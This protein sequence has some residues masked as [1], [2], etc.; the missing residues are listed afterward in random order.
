M[1]KITIL[2]LFVLFSFTKCSTHKS[3]DTTDTLD[4]EASTA[5]LYKEYTGSYKITSHPTDYVVI[6]SRGTELY[7]KATNRQKAQLFPDSVDGLFNVPEFNV[8]VR[9]IR[10]SL[11]KINSF[12]IYDSG[13]QVLGVRRR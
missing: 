8:K 5:A 12:I 2:L 13:Q 11:Q 10:D 3:P 7:G 4:T 9:F 1:K 6:T